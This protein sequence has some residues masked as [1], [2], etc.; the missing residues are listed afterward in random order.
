MAAKGI[1]NSQYSGT[2]ALDTTQHQDGTFALVDLTRASA[3]N[4]FLHDGFYD[5]NGNPDPGCG[6]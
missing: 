5:V 1:G 3:Y 6:R 2:V 4:P